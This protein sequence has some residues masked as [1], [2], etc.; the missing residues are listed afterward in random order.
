[1]RAAQFSAL[2]RL[3]AYE[4]RKGKAKGNLTDKEAGALRETWYLREILHARLQ[5]DK[6]LLRCLLREAWQRQPSLRSKPA[7]LTNLL[8]SFLM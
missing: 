6:T 5:G 4:R 7:Y 3:N 1:M 2:A 8:R